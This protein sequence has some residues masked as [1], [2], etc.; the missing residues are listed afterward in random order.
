[1]RARI[2]ILLLDAMRFDHLTNDIT[3]NLMRIAKDGIFYDNCIAGGTATL[4]SMP[5]LL[6][7]VREYDPEISVMRRLGK[8]GFLSVLI[9]SNP[10]VG[11]NFSSG[12]NNVVDL[13]KGN[14]GQRRLGLRRFIRKWF[15]P[16]VLSFIRVFYRWLQ[17]EEGYLPYLRA[18]ETLSAASN[19]LEMFE[20]K[21]L[22]LWVH[23]MDPHL[24]YYPKDISKFEI[25]THQYVANLND[26]LVDAVHGRYQP[27]VKE[28]ETYKLLYRM[29]VSEMDT[30]IGQFYDS[31]DMSDTLLIITADHGDEF[32]EYGQF[33]HSSNKFVD[34][35]QHVP[36][37]V[38]GAEKGTVTEEFSHYNF[39]KLVMDWALR[40]RTSI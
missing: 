35:L 1:M 9:H 25:T 16:F 23:M 13:K 36:L 12:W 40:A 3:P 2:I 30:A 8:L 15:P 27:S 39:T 11:R 26:K 14:W 18:D 31:L 19:I 22:F 32:G 24:P 28:I 29:E 5:V 7:G 37:I 4:E 21:Q 6:C 33:S 38:V 34:V 10:L 20:A 17:R